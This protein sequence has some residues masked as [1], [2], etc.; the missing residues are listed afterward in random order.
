MVKWTAVEEKSEEFENADE[1]RR[2]SYEVAS[3]IADG[4]SKVVSPLSL[5]V[6]F[7]A[8]A[9]VASSVYA[10][11]TKNGIAGDSKNIEV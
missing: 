6:V 10:G 11:T 2:W 7:E 9:A 3:R 8:S 1:T 5:N 4:N